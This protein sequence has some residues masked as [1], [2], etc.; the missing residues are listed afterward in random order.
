MSVPQWPRLGK[1]QVH[2]ASELKSLRRL[3]RP[4]R[5][6]DLLSQRCVVVA[7]QRQR[8]TEGHAH[9]CGRAND[10]P[11]GRTRS[12]SSIRTGTTGTS[13]R[14]ADHADAAAERLDVAGR[15][16]ACPPGKISTDQPAPV[17]SPMYFSVWRAPASRCGSGKALKKNAAR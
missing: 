17:S 7:A 10:E 4:H 16:T 14:D 9:R 13:R 6:L 8:R 5:V 15:A 12:T 1:L 3:Q 2:F 11:V